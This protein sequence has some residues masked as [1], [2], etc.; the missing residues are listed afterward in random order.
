[1][2]DSA[3][4]DVACP[5]CDAGPLELCTVRGRYMESTVHFPRRVRADVPF[6]AQPVRRNP[7][8]CQAEKHAW[9]SDNTYT[10]RDGRE[11]CRLCRDNRKPRKERKQLGRPAGTHCTRGHERTPENTY[12][13]TGGGRYCIPCKQL[14]RK[15]AKA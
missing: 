5:V 7:E 1:M 3:L 12:T 14:N 2:I 15:K 6:E 10:S 8:L 9:T 13:P 11:L 4:F